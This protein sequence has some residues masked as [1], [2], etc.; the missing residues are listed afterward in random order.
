MT[1][2]KYKGV[3]WRWVTFNT[4]MKIIIYQVIK[5]V[6]FIWCKWYLRPWCFRLSVNSQKF[7]NEIFLLYLDTLWTPVCTFINLIIINKI[8]HYHRWMKAFIT[9][10]IVH[11]VYFCNPLLFYYFSYSFLPILAFRSLPRFAFIN[12]LNNLSKTKL[13]S[14]ESIFWK[15]HMGTSMCQ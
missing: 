11:T 15:K 13:Y 10:T 1:F 9:H 5:V 7:F 3:H 2:A 12:I 4:S 14:E 8:Q 6:Y